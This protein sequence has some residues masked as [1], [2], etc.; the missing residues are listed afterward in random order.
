VVKRR[1]KV[2]QINRLAPKGAYVAKLGY[3]AAVDEVVLPHWQSALSPHRLIGTCRFNAPRRSER[4][5][6]RKAGQLAPSDLR[7]APAPEKGEA[8]TDHH[9]RH[10]A[11]RSRRGERSDQGQSVQRKA[12]AEQAEGPC[13]RR[14][15]VVL[16]SG[17]EQQ[18]PYRE[19]DVCENGHH[20][21]GDGV[22]ADAAAPLQKNQ[23]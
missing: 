9:Y 13:A 10:N 3:Q 20:R 2:G 5:A 23:Q 16:S 22:R 19:R 12:G 15:G 18:V 1:R 17:G 11:E 21:D 4:Y 8:K 7:S 6:Q 14:P